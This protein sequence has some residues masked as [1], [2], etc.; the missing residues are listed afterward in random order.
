MRKDSWLSFMR[1]P[2]SGGAQQAGIVATLRTH[3]LDARREQRKRALFDFVQHVFLKQVPTVHYTARDHD[4]L[5]I[6]DVDEIR[7]ADTEVNAHASKDLQRELV[8]LQAGLEDRFRSEIAARVQHRLR[9]TRTRLARHADDRRRRR[10]HFQTAATAARARD[11]AKRIDA[12]VPDFRR[13]AVNTAPQLAVENDPATDTGA[14]RHTND[15]AATLRRALPHLPDRRR[16]RIVL[17]NRRQIKLV[18][19]RGGERKAVE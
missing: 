5:W 10:E 3:D 14:E 4:H 17:E 8:A 18:R 9:I 1:E 16:V 6:Q 11:A 13:G 2:E 15:R 7:E 19:Q 12:H